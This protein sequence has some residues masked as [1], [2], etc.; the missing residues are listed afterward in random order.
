MQL[1]NR[2]I[3]LVCLILFLGVGAGLFLTTAAR[4]PFA[5][6][7]FIADNISPS[8]LTSARLFA[9]GG[10]G[11]LQ[12][13]DFPACA[14]CRNAANDFSVPESA[15]ASTEIA[16]GKRVNSGSLC[17][18]PSGL[19]L[20][21]L[22]EEAS[23]K[24][25]YTGLVTSGPITGAT[26]AAY[27]AKTLNAGN[28]QDVL[29]Q[30]CSH[31]PFDFVAGGGAL[32]FDPSSKGNANPKEDKKTPLNQLNEKGVVVLRTMTDLEKQPFWTRVP[33][34][35]L[36][37]PGPL[38]LPN[39]SEGDPNTPTLA[40]L[41]RVAITHLQSNRHGYMLVVD[42]PMVASASALNDAE[43]MF[44]RL[45]AFD[46]AV[47]TAR[48]YAGENSLI[49]VTG[50]ENIGGLQLNGYPFLR[51][52]GV[53]ILALNNQGIPSLCWST[54]P[55]FPAEKTPDTTVTKKTNP[56]A[57]GILSQPSAYRLG[58]AA[59]VAGDVLT[60]GSG[61]GSEKI[62]GFLELTDIHRILKEGL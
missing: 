56:P 57:V 55:G 30:F 36:L 25:R 6:I 37:A 48:R 22:L 41:V 15:S 32:D 2:L 11:R 49:I 58:S 61:Q 53:A 54:G 31:S 19:K 12:M 9:S 14:L 20:P 62:R 46:R 5:V 60:L 34:L 40:D 27:Y 47:A 51:D 29:N 17:I 16:A 10:D 4:K 13:E 18:D 8:V 39:F 7:L 24:G 35:G 21:S 45:L 59:G 50:R 42:D 23:S 44:N 26:A 52:K 43:T 28:T 3:A 38:P 1:R 33:I